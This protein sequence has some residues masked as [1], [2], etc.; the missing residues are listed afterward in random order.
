MLN[1]RSFDDNFIN[2]M[3]NDSMWICMNLLHVFYVS[4]ISLTVNVDYS[5][6]FGGKYGVQ[7]D[8]KDKSAVG[9][10][11]QEKLEKHESQ[12][13]LPPQRPRP[14]KIISFAVGVWSA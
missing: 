9:W 8:R 1:P 7:T 13:G 12:Q 4:W 14:L 11:H 5:T 2:Q 10:E 3:E 6:G